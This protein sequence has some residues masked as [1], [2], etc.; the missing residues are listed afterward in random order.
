MDG[1]QSI[2]VE[3]ATA[4]RMRRLE[5]ED[6]AR[7][8]GMWSALAAAIVLALGTVAYALSGQWTDMA[9]YAARFNGSK[10]IV[11]VL[12]FLLTV[13]FVPAVASIH[14]VTPERRRLL[15]LTGLAFAVMYATICIGD[16]ALQFTLVR[17]RILSG[18]LTGLEPWVSASPNSALFALDGL[19]FF[20]QGIS[21]LF[22]APLFGGSRLMDTIKWLFIVNGI[23]SIGGILMISLMSLGSASGQALYL[24]STV[25]WATLLMIALILLAVAFQRRLLPG[26]H[27]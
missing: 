16:C 1:Q 4:K 15:S 26:F 25:V 5:S 19:A 24:A 23:L 9:T 2:G 17:Q 6:L 13:F 18:N 10:L 3:K 11:W 14:A 21:T 22:L 20:L 27:E 7:N 12:F 8:L